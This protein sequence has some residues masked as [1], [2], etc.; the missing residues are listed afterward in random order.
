MSTHVHEQADTAIAGI[1]CPLEQVL[2]LADRFVEL[3]QRD[4]S[5][6]AYFV[7]FIASALLVLRLGP[8]PK[9]EVVPANAGG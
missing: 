8:Y 1:A 2:A 5:V 4:I 3:V 9:L 7:L 6:R